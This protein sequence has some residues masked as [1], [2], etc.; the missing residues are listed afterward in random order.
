M[1]YIFSIFLLSFCYFQTLAQSKVE[2]QIQL[3]TSDLIGEVTLDSEPFFNWIQNLNETIETTLS[4]ETGNKEIIVFVDLHKDKDVTFRISARPSIDAIRLE[5]LS[6]LLKQHKNIRAKYLDYSFLVLAKLNEGI[7]ENEDI[8]FE[9]EVQYPL[10]IELNRFK[11]LDLASQKQDLQLWVINEVIPVLEHYETIVD[12]KFEGVLAVGKILK[13]KSFL[14]TSVAQLTAHNH[15]YWRATMEM[16]KGNQLIPFTKVCLYISH[17]EYDRA[18]RLLQMINVFSNQSSLPAVLNE[19]LSSKIN[20]L[21]N[22][23]NQHIE[24]GIKLHDEKKYVEAISHYE[25]LLKTIPN[26]AWLNYELYYSKSAILNSIEENNALW[27][28]S[29]ATIY[30]CD[31][32]YPINARAQSGKEGYLLFRRQ[33][34]STLFKSNDNFKADIISY[35]DIALDLKN[36]EFAAQLYW[37]ITTYF[38]DKDKKQRNILA[39][40]LYCLHQLGDTKII[41]NFE[42][43]YSSIF[44]NI[45]KEREQLMK[46]SS[47]YK[48]F[49]N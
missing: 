43:D 4:K 15:N 30:N 40:Y 17:G 46:E 36:Y 20:I 49:N 39:H 21:N 48:S 14:N 37:L 26:S 22:S 47:I 1:K 2:L 44:E 7:P 32:M 45:S 29:K 13:N 18:N 41:K 31:P 42:G 8:A 19:E 35:A 10:N 16:S 38:S 6:K 11:A 28:T 5:E 34:I 3:L 24:K 33:E 12:P 25:S 23:I 9:P 27:E